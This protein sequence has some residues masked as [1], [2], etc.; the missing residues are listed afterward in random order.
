MTKFNL[1]EYIIIIIKKRM[2]CVE[3]IIK[4]IVSRSGYWRV[5]FR[6]VSSIIGNFQT[7]TF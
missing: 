6:Y 3:I 1:N 5:T 2:I 7:S 4:K